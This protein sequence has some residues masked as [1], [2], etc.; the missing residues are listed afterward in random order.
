MKQHCCD[1]NNFLVITEINEF[2]ALQR[3]VGTYPIICEHLSHHVTYNDIFIHS[4]NKKS[5]S[6]RNSKPGSKYN[7]T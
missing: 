5:F 2:V 1:Q 4:C 3:F 6:I 7:L